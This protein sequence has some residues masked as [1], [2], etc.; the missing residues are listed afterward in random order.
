MLSDGAKQALADMAENIALIREFVRGFTID[1]FQAD[2]RTRYAVSRAVEILSEASRRVPA[3]IKS[4]WP[5]FDWR[6]LAAIGNVFRHEYHQV[7]YQMVWALVVNRLDEL[8]SIVDTE[9][10]RHGGG[11]G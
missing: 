8:S 9:L 11:P 6:G 4:G 7:D 2:A 10:G 5:N 3:N 1:S